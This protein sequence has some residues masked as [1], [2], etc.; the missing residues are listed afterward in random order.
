MI[1]DLYSDSHEQELKRSTPNPPAKLPETG[2]LA[3]IDLPSPKRPPAAPVGPIKQ[4]QT[5]PTEFTPVGGEPD[6]E[7]SFAEQAKQAGWPSG[8][9]PAGSGAP[10]Q[11][12]EPATFSDA[13]L[14]QLAKKVGS[15]E[16][17]R[18][19][20]EQPQFA[21]QLSP[22]EPKQTQP[23]PPQPEPQPAQQQGPQ[24]QGP[25]QQG[26]Q[27]PP[28]PPEELIAPP[29]ERTPQENAWRQDAIDRGKRLAGQDQWLEDHLSAAGAFDATPQTISRFA[30]RIGLRGAKLID[31]P[32]ALRAAIH[33]QGMQKA[34]RAILERTGYAPEPRKSAMRRFGEGL[35][36]GFGNAKGIQLGQKAARGARDTMLDTVFG[37][38]R[39]QADNYAAATEEK[40][41]T[42]E[43]MTPLERA[44]YDDEDDY[45]SQQT[46]GKKEVD[47]LQADNKP[48]KS[49][50]V[51]PSKEIDNEEA[52]EGDQLGLF[53]GTGK[54]TT[55]QNKFKLENEKEKAKQGLMFDRMNDHPD[56]QSL[57]STFGE[58]VARY[59]ADLKKK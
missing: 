18:K 45:K 29:V 2:P 3:D 55:K 38:R 32:D 34:L 9:S 31:T 52:E 24:Q 27:Q 11:Q 8:V 12:Q 33:G 57:F 10:P 56:Q 35:V 4:E 37:K 22:Q 17:A 54:K 36:E 7:P 44:M 19:L 40:S 5:Q 50:I 48:E 39:F 51:M 46:Y 6:A 28:P 20:L 30:E 41:K 1:R 42:W 49:G 43:T 15:E 14:K 21:E 53:E 26:P 23:K 58:A 25:Q 13:A 47:R 16:V 59:Q